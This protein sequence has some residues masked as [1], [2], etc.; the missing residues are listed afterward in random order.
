[1]PKQA[2]QSP[3]WWVAAKVDLPEGKSGDVEVR[4]FEVAPTGIEQ[5]RLAWSGRGIEPGTYTG[6]YRRGSLWMSDT[7][8]EIRDCMSVFS[9]M[10]ARGGRVLMNGLGLG[11]TVKYALSLPNVEHVDVVEIDPDVAALVGPTYA[12]DRC[13]VHLGDAYAMKWPAGTR[14]SIAWH[15]VWP[16]ICGDNAEGI[17]RLKRMYGRRVDWQAAWCEYEVRRANRVGW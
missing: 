9:E 12:G 14:W 15:D 3:P 16:N 5:M 10:R 2:V 17:A 7:P 6:L 4:T 13:T 8:A 11:M 1:M